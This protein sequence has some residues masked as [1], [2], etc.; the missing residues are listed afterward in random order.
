M[1][2]EKIYKMIIFAVLIILLT[3]NY[4][5]N[6]LSNKEEIVGTTPFY[7]FQSDSEYLVISK[8]F[9]D[10]FNKSSSKYGLNAIINEEGNRIDNIYINEYK[11]EYSILDYPSQVGIQGHIFSFM[12]N[13]LHISIKLLRLIC[14]TLL[15]VIL[16]GISYIIS[17]KYNKILGVIFYLTFLLSPWIVAFARNLYW[18]EF[19]WFLPMLLSLIISVNYSKKRLKICIPLIFVSIFIKCLCGY[20]YITTIMFA[21]IS[22][23]IIDF[24]KT[25]DKKERITILKNIF[26]VGLVCLI[27]FATAIVLH[28]VL[29]GNGNVKEGI[30]SIYKNDVLRRTVISSN[31]VKYTGAL[32]ESTGAGILETVRKYFKWNTNIILGIEGKYFNVIFVSCLLILLYRIYKKD[33]EI[34]NDTIMFI[35]FLACTI[36]WL[37][38]GK[39]HSYLHTHINFVLWYFGFIQICLYIIF[40]FICNS[41]YNIGKNMNTK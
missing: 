37:V 30:V 29:R 12:Y 27:A 25:I 4:S 16:V 8:I 32:G 21:A 39:A 13:K 23:F 14:C 3:L 36:S 17:K 15:A 19:T 2:R 7:G 1:N 31:S 9:T 28:A 11:D 18:V 35:V 26:I 38:L 5:V 10:Y 24:F 41:I 34:K 33:K 22:F 20:E 6:F 40:K